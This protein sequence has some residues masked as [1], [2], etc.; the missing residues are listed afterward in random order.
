MKKIL[1]DIQPEAEDVLIKLLRQVPPWQKCKQVTQMIQTC[2]ELSLSGLKIRYP[3]ASKKELEK[4]LAALWL[5]RGLVIQ[6]Y[7]WDPEKEGY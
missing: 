7:G 3:R 6:V 1:K 4:R 2:R 5:P